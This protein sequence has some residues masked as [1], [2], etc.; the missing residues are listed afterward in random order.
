M[1]KPF[2]MAC[3]LQTA[4]LCGPGVR[5]LQ[6]SLPALYLLRSL[7]WGLTALPFCPPRC[8]FINGGAWRKRG[9]IF[10]TYDSA[11]MARSRSRRRP[12]ASR[13]YIYCL[14]CLPRHRSASSGLAPCPWWGGKLQQ[15]QSGLNRCR[16]HSPLA[17][18]SSE[19][20]FAALESTSSA[21]TPPSAANS[22]SFC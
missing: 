18:C 4:A 5:G 3:M 1:A 21:A 2:V 11:A 7:S 13:A 16:S 10:P 12:P 14:G 20:L 8:K 15:G 17:G 19:S 6:T 9:A 22:P